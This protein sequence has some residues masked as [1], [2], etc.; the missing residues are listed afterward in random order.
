MSGFVKINGV[1]KSVPDI[2]FDEFSVFSPLQQNLERIVFGEKYQ[3]SHSVH[4]WKRVL[5]GTWTIELR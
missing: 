3:L 2:Y 4:L 1:I 5:L